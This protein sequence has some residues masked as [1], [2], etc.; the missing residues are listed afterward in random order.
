M[1]RGMFPQA[2]VLWVDSG[3]FSGDNSPAGKFQT[4]TLLEGMS[5][6]GYTAANVTERELSVGLEQLQTLAGKAQFPL[7]SGNIVWQADGKPVFSP[8]TIKTLAPGSWRG[9]APLRIGILGLCKGN[10]GFLMR[11]SDDRKVVIQS[12][13]KTAARLVPPLRQQSDLV[14]LLTNLTAP[15]VDTLLAAVPGVDLVLA[16]D[17]EL[18]SDN[19]ASPPRASV[20][21][22]GNQGKRLGE[23]RVFFNHQ[24]LSQV[25]KTHPFL[26]SRFPVDPALKTFE[27]Q[28]NV[29]I[30]EFYREAAA[31]ETSVVPGQVPPQSLFFGAAECKSCHEAAYPVWERSGHAHAMQSLIDVGQEFNPLCVA[32]HVTGNR[33]TNGFRNIK[34]T[35]NFANVQCEACHGA[36]GAHM[37][38]PS[39][40]YGKLDENS[41]VS[42]HTKDNSPEFVFPSYWERIRH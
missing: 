26:D 27:D 4:E 38:D 22:A 7:L 41:C 39:K 11:T 3:E 8:A 5:R 6:L 35:P 15:E 25:I 19:M 33:R 32:C 20:M 17:G 12:P 40:P 9:D 31:T 24:G 1:F 23:V 42:C 18:V 21:Y 34:L 10:A 13:V 29:K 2:P 36:A 16:G 37:Q 28:A 14:I 30:N